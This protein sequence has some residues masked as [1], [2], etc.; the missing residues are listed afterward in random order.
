M[1]SELKYT[2][3]RS[4]RVARMMHIRPIRDDETSSLQ[5]VS[6]VSREAANFC[7]LTRSGRSPQSTGEMPDPRGS[8]VNKLETNRTLGRTLPSASLPTRVLASVRYGTAIATASLLA[9]AAGSASA[10][11]AQDLRAQ[12]YEDLS[13]FTSVL[14]LVRNNYVDEVD[15]H[16][17]LMSAMRGILKDL[18]PH[19]SFMSPDAFE[20]M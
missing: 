7:K 6:S 4:K 8:F 3:D 12:R 14:E 16:A 13:V 9:L 19:S 17:I 10:D 15:E 1:G 18:D 2:R 11:E 5:P 20:D